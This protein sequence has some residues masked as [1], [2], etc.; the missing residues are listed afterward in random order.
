M[1]H[2]P[3]GSSLYAR[4]KVSHHDGFMAKVADTVGAGDAFTAALAMGLWRGDDL[5]RITAH[6]N[7]LASYVC[8]QSG[9]MPPIPADLLAR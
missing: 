9:A 5:D 6:A 7:R 4:D 8:S 1:V 2:G 3:K